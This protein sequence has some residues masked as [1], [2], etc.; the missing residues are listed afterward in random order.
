MAN[1]IKNR[2]KQYFIN[3]KFQSDFIIKFCILVIA[4]S[5]ISGVIIYFMSKS[6]VT[7]VFENSRLTIKSTADFIL[8]AV[9]LSS[10][11]VIVLIGLAAV[12]VTV[13]TSHRIAGPLYRIEKDTEEVAGG[14]LNKKFDLR[15][16]DELKLLAQSFNKMTDNLRS[17]IASIKE[18]IAKL[19]RKA[20]L[21]LK[22]ELENLKQA[23]SKF[24]T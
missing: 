10:C 19:E 13:F 1:N 8:P 14:N 12:W 6:T 23:V 17:G 5:F 9:L 20:P 11:A 22:Q 16:T 4:G 21:D 2:R 18:A 24:K 7:T 15:N 3:R